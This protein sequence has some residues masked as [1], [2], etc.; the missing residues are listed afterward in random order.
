MRRAQEEDEP[1]P[2]DLEEERISRRGA[3]G[4]PPE[5]SCPHGFITLDVCPVCQMIARV[6]RREEDDDGESGSKSVE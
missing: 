3:G 4:G 2:E 5:P 1:D 6:R